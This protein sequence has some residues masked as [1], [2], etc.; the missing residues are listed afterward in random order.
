MSQADRKNIVLLDAHFVH[1]WLIAAVD[2]TFVNPWD[3]RQLSAWRW[4]H[5][6]GHTKFRGRRLWWGYCKTVYGTGKSRGKEGANQA[7]GEAK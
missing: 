2:R 3:F 6:R 7:V 5:C 1:R 4:S